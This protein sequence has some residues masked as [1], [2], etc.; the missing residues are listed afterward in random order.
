GVN[1]NGSIATGGCLTNGSLL[2]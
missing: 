2:L 1:V